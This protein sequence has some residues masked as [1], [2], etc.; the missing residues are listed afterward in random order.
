[1]IGRTLSH[2]KVLE[3]IGTGGMGEVYLAQDTKL[4]REVAIKVLP[5]A[6]SKNKERLAR[7]EREAKLLAS[8]NHPNIAAI[9]QLEESDGVHFLALEYVPG[10]TLLERIKRGPIPT[11][12]A[13]P[14][15]KQIAEGLE[16]AHE[17]GI[18][19]RDLKPANIKVT[20]EG[21][22]KVLDFGLAKA[23]AGEIPTQDLSESPTV[24]REHTETGVLLGTA[25]YMS[26]EQARGKTVDKRTDIWAFG[27]CL[28]EALSGKATF[29]GDTV[30]DTIAGILK[31][32]PDWQALPHETPAILRSV[33]RQCLKK[34]PNHRLQHIGDARV[35]IEEA[36]G[37]PLPAGAP[38]VSRPALWRSA[39]PWCLTA[40]LAAVALW[41]LLRTTPLQP[42]ALKRAAITL[43]P[44][45]A[46]I[47]ASALALSP[48]GKQVVYAAQTGE[49]SQ[50]FLRALDDFEAQPIP[51]TEGG[52]CPFFSLDGQWVG[53]LAGPK[54]KKV[55]IGGGAPVTLYDMERGRTWGASWGPDDRIYFSRWPQRNSGGNIWRIP[56]H[57]GEPEPLTERRV[58]EGE[59]SH[60]LPEVLPNGNGVLFTLSDEALFETGSYGSAKIAVLSL[61][62]GERRIL[63]EDAFMPKYAA[64][65][66]FY[67]SRGALMAVPFDQGSLELAGQ[68]VTLVDNVL[69]SPGSGWANFAISRGGALAYVPGSAAGEEPR[70][71]V[72]VDRKGETVPVTNKPHAYQYARMSPEGR[73]LALAIAREGNRD[74]WIYEISRDTMTRLTFTWE[75]ENWPVWHPDGT[76]VS[77]RQFDPPTQN[78]YWIPADGSGE[79][80]T[81]LDGEYTQYP[82]SWSQDGRLLVFTE[83]HPDTGADIG[84]LPIEGNRKPRTFIKTPFDEWDG[85]LSPDGHWIAY[86]SNETGRNEVY[87]TTFPDPGAKRR[88]STDGGH[89]PVWAPSGKEL[90]YRSERKLTA[91]AVETGP[92]LRIGTPRLLFEADFA[93]DF[94][95]YDI[96]PDGQRFVIIQGEEKPQAEIRVI[97]N[98]P[99]ELKRLVPTEN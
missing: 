99:E 24:T 28:Y 59:F 36:L 96:T 14:L 54:I 60:D 40:I 58:D 55:M 49:Q 25:P 26:P 44:G 4:D 51:G 71:L 21:K 80:E 37:A 11:D 5:E 56:A 41:A 16:A 97:L 39:I 70:A 91:V 62:T 63:I 95:S 81:L 6:F 38:I 34:D 74:L 93:M 8:L 92:D 20:P 47:N 30:S 31:Q 64:G 98:W 19:H 76:R 83:I 79:A 87:V 67:I 42:T 73:R 15:F 27:C 43:P 3:K 68:P 13:L 61:E 57:G 72:W 17:K 90:F 77:Y 32:E 84:V 29:L 88:V 18:I 66:L 7:F 78:I 85:R 48:D 46:W 53:F 89:S 50:L 65:R 52:Q 33:L 35:E 82:N 1:M 86:V 9:H 2:Y 23:M 10:E 94:S 69:W 12:E 45:Q 75:N 22:A